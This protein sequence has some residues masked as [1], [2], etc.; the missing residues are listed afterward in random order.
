MLLLIFALICFQINSEFIYGQKNDEPFYYLNSK[1]IDLD[2][3]YL[4]PLRL[5]SI[6]VQRQTQSGKVLMF[7]KNSEF[8]F[9]RLPDILKKYTNISGLN[10]SVLFKING[11]LIEDTTSIIIDDTYFVY[12]TTDKLNSVKYISRQFRNLTIVNI[13]LETKRREPVI[14]IRG[15][16]DI[17]DKL[18]K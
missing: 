7:T 11:K 6:S 14:Y 1:R 12:V 9:Y 3:V 13:D 4:N 5:D 18:K 16:N 15:N 10:D 17:L 8:S 2:R